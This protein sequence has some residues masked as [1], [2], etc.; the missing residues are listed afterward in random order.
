VW[1]RAIA[2]HGIKKE[3]RIGYST[4]LNYPQ[5]PSAALRQGVILINKSLASLM[6]AAR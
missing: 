4:G 5:L 3:S 1:R 6:R 2:K